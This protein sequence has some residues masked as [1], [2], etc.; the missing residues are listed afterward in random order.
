MAW[1]WITGD[2]LRSFIKNANAG[3]A[4]LLD[5][6]AENA[7]ETVE[8]LCGPIEYTTVTD[9]LVRVHGAEKVKLALSVTRGLTKVADALSG[10][11]HD[12]TQWVAD[13]QVLR[14]VY[15]QPI[16]RDLKVSYLTGWVDSTTPGA[17]APAWA[18]A[19]ALAIAAQHVRTMPR[20]RQNGE[21]T[22]VGFIVPNAALELAGDHL[23]LK[24]GGTS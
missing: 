4:D 22:P 7:R 17:K 14:H 20:F 21:Q 23:L 11:E 12:L 10:F 2:D 3:D 19:M 18:R 1:E 8:Y 13:G 16:Y 9:E 6:A 24:D 15:C 5:L